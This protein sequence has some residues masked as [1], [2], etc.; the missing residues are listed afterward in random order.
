MRTCLEIDEKKTVALMKDAAERQIQEAVTKTKKQQWVSFWHLLTTESYD[1]TWR[2]DLAFFRFV[3]WWFL[4]LF[5]LQCANCGKEAMF[6]CCWNTSY[7]DLRCQHNHWWKHVS[8]CTQSTSL[9]AAGARQA[10]DL[11]AP[12]YRQNPTFVADSEDNRSEPAVSKVCWFHFDPHSF[13][14]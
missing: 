13:F 5:V 2:F 6:Y 4:I 1:H 8:Q 3:W 10:A 14:S 9:V 12:K 7:C 11:N